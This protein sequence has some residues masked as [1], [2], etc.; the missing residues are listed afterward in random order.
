MESL[1]TSKFKLSKSLNVVMSVVLIIHP[2]W[3][4]ESSVFRDA[5]NTVNVKLRLQALQRDAYF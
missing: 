4:G 2:A 3:A 5:L 1:I